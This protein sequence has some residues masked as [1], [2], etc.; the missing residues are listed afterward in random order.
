MKCYARGRCHRRNDISTECDSWAYLRITSE[1][2]LAEI[3]DHLG[4]ESDEPSWSIGDQRQNAPH[5]LYKFSCWKLKSGLEVGAPLD[6][7]LIS[8]WQRMA[9]HRDV[10]CSLPNDMSACVQCVAHFKS[11]RDKVAIAAGHYSTAAYYQMNIDC[12]FYFEDDFGHEEDG[13]PY[14][15]WS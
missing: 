12:D 2:P 9:S 11:H 4:F 15:L 3:C 5:S 8:L 1:R 14:W 6:A 10:L 13:K 7:H